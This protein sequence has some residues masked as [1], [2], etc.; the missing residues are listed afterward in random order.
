MQPQPG[1]C[2]V[3]THTCTFTHFRPQQQ[4]P[5]VGVLVVTA[6]VQ[7]LH[8]GL[9]GERRM[10]SDLGLQGELLSLSLHPIGLGRASPWRCWPGAAAPPGEMSP[11]G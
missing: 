9:W 10:R 1:F 5:G 6:V 11:W 4:S 8:H 3:C 7:Q 2:S